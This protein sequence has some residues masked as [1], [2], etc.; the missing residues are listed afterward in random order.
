MSDDKLGAADRL[1]ID[2]RSLV[3]GGTLASLGGL[4]LLRTPEPS[5]RVISTEEF[6]AAIPSKV[7][8]WTSRRSAELV[9]PELDGGE[10]LYEN[11]ET[12]I[13]EGSNLPSIMFL[14]AYSSVQI[15]DVQVHRPEVCYPVAGLPIISSTPTTFQFRGKQI[16]ARDVIADRRGPEEQILYWV[17]VGNRFPTTWLDQRMAMASDSLKGTLP[18]GVLVRISTIQKPG[19]RGMPILKDFAR[20]LLDQSETKFRDTILV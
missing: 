13:Y 9:L 10:K 11:L 20:Q 19:Y 7:G 16:A 4:A 2:R 1:S 17:R 3:I 14:V 12:R 5:G 8:G 15:N 6:R 18:D